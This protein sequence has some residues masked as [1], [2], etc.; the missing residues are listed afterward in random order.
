MS[1]LSHTTKI[2]GSIF[3]QNQLQLQIE[4]SPKG[5]PIS[6]ITEEACQCEMHVQLREKKLPDDLTELL[7]LLLLLPLL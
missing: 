4:R 1:A 2:H 5:T 3:S 6:A 7:V